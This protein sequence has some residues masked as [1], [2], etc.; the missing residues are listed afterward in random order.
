MGDFVQRV[1]PTR[2]VFKPHAQN[3]YLEHC[4]QFLYKLAALIHL[5]YG[6]PARGEEFVMMRIANDHEG[7][8]SLFWQEDRLWIITGYHKG[9]NVTGKDKTIA[10]LLPAHVSAMVFK[11]LHLVRPVEDFFA[12]EVAQSLT[13]V[14]RRFTP[15][16]RN[17]VWMSHSDR[18]TGQDFT[19]S[20]ISAFTDHAQVKIGVADWRQILGSEDDIRDLQVG[21]TTHTANVRYAIN[22]AG[23]HSIGS[24][25]LSEF[26]RA[27]DEWQVVAQCTLPPD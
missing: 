14:G 15:S 3:K 21:H 9:S 4:R 20:L 10:R 24:L 26:K 1:E 27:S 5:T 11:Y 19:T 16:A 22:T 17:H 8:R 23:A 25:H 7:L 6:G 12:R 13:P 2:V 18:W